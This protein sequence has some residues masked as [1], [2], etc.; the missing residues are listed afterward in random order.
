MFTL[1]MDKFRGFQETTIPLVEVNFLVGEN[2]TGKSSL[3]G[4]ANLLSSPDFWFSQNFNLPEYEFGGFVDIL[5]AGCKRTEEFSFGA[6]MSLRHRETREEK[7]YTYLVSYREKDSLPMLSLFSCLD[8][9]RLISFR[10]FRNTYRR[11]TETL[12]AE[13]IP[14]NKA[15]KFALLRSQSLRA[16]EDFSAL[17]K[18]LP[19]R[20]GLIPMLAMLEGESGDKK[21]DEGVFMLPVPPLG[22]DVAWLAPIRTKPKR[23]YDGY[24]Q[25]FSPEGEHTPY[26]IRKKLESRTGAQEFRDALSRFGAES[27]L[28]SDVTVHDLGRDAVS[29]FE[30]M[31]RLRKDC[32]LRINSVGYGVSQVLP[33]V[34]EMLARRKNSWFAMQQPEVHLHPRAQGALGDVIY[35][36]A[37]RDNKRFLIET[38]SDFTIDRF[39]MNYRNNPQHKS[40]AQVLFFQRDNTGNHVCRI[41]IEKNGE[42]SRDQ[43]PA[44]REFFL[45]EQMNVLGL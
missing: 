10:Q 6:A 44:F 42:Y 33:L 41:P 20:G 43:P 17:P 5:S 9:N 21:P 13:H 35:N 22:H 39:R 15:A 34:V 14:K 45:K 37:E 7:D 28:F 1:Y 4:L 25:P 3:L 32:D 27:G 16:E 2:S 11:C 30:L 29:P 38:H 36:V 8:G 18:S 26:I 19:V 24:G 23:T 31:I 12:H 40:N